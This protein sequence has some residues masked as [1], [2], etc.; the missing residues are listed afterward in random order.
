MNITKRNSK[1][2]L[3]VTNFFDG[4]ALAILK[5][6]IYGISKIVKVDTNYN[7]IEKTN[8]FTFNDWFNG[9]LIVYEEISDGYWFDYWFDTNLTKVPNTKGISCFL[10]L[11]FHLKTLRSSNVSS[12]VTLLEIHPEILQKLQPMEGGKS[13]FI[14]TPFCWPF[15]YTPNANKFNTIK[16]VHSNIDK[17]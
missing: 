16:F 12:I 17:W 6:R 2:F 8:Y 13:Y 7:V 1:K 5:P 3:Y 10:S 14:S 9:Y 4:Q 11:K 15:I